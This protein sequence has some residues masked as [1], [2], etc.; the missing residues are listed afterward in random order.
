PGDVV[1]ITGGLGGIGRLVARHLGLRRRARVVLS[2]R[3]A[4]DADGTRFLDE[5]RRDGA[6]V[7]YLS[8]D[9]A[10]EDAARNTVRE[11]EQRHGRLD[12]IIHSAGV[13]AD[14]AIV[15]KTAVQVARVLRPKVAGV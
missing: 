4:P 14:D 7:A 3:S 1:W 12:W 5:L 11:I 6:N 2:G 13:I 15:A 10:Q 8:C 9:I